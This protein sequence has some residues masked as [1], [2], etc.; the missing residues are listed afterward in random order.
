MMPFSLAKSIEMM[1]PLITPPGLRRSAA[2]AS[3]QAAAELN[4]ARRRA[5]FHSSAHT[6]S[7]QQRTHFSASGA[8]S[9]L[10]TLTTAVGCH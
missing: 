10:G 1:M 4:A 6:G 8:A 9:T 7:A 3:R 2:C 5:R